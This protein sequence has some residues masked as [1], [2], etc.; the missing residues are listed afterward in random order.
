MRRRL[1]CRAVILLP[2]T[3]SASSDVRAQG[4]FVGG[5]ILEKLCTQSASIR[6]CD[7]YIV[8]IVDAL[9]TDNIGGSKACIPQEGVTQDQLRRTV[10]DWL[11]RHPERRGGNGAQ[12]VA[13]ALSETFPC[14]E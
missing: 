11:K 4:W 7:G 14:I 2:L 12:L 5:F 1:S 9:A 3:L 8:A 6:E 10:I 13:R